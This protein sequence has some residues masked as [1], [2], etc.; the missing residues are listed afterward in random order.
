MEIFF[1]NLYYWHDF[2]YEILK[3]LTHFL[4]VIDQFRDFLLLMA[5]AIQYET[6]YEGYV[7]DN[8][9]PDC[10]LLLRE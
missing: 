1:F 2:F 6:Q 5:Q 4:S 3:L 10:L 7:E 9:H 8:F